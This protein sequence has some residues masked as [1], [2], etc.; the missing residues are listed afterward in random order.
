MNK[1]D[2]QIHIEETHEQ[3]ELSHFEQ[4]K[5]LGY[6]KGLAND[7]NFFPEIERVDTFAFLSGWMR[8]RA[9]RGC[10]L[11]ASHLVNLPKRK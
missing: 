3:Q 11:C 4:S 10:D 2:T 7:C 5:Q 6:E 9:E 1:Y 8:G